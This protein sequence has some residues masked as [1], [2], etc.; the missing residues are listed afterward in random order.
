MAWTR[1]VVEH[2]PMRP[3][4]R[5]ATSAVVTCALLASLVSGCTVTHVVPRRAYAS[6]DGMG[7]AAPVTVVDHRGR[8]TEITSGETISI[9]HCITGKTHTAS[10]SE[11]HVGPE[12]FEAVTVRG[13]PVRFKLANICKLRVQKTSAG[14]TVGLTLGAIGAAFVTLIVVAAISSPGPVMNAK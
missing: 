8:P 12:L 5:G 11:I 2:R 13:D 7:K 1:R 9:D 4:T 10:Y 14:L 6:L 3:R